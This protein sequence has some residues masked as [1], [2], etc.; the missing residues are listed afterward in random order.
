MTFPPFSDS[1]LL[2]LSIAATCVLSTG[3]TTD[4]PTPVASSDESFSVM[5][6]TTAQD[7]GLSS[8]PSS[9]SPGALSEPALSSTV[10]AE[11]TVEEFQGLRVRE[12]FAAVPYDRDF[13]GQRWSDAGSVDL[14]RN[15]CDTRNDILGRD[16]SDI[17][18]KPG[19][20]DC[21][22]LQGWFHDPYDGQRIEFVRGRGTSALVPIDHVV[23]LA[24]AWTTG[25]SEWDSAKLLNFANDPTN[26]RATTL[27]NNMAKGAWDPATW[28]PSRGFRCDYVR[29]RLDI[30][31][32]YELAITPKERA[33]SARVLDNC[34]STKS[35]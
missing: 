9:S 12:R 32:V 23:A 11:P 16:L 30:K 31:R 3:C 7:R 6:P 17:V 21:V 2:P 24:D 18:F 5:R 14:S 33:A 20:R 34:M 29:A 22:V 19:T 4:S 13:F 27:Q 25:A 35:G 15:G 1:Y 26:L 28:L 8:A 10:L